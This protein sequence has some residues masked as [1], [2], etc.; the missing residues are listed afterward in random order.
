MIYL[1]IEVYYDELRILCASMGIIDNAKLLFFIYLMRKKYNL[2][3]FLVCF[4]IFLNG[5]ESKESKG[6]LSFPKKG[7]YMGI[8]TISMCSHFCTFCQEIGVKVGKKNTP[9]TLFAHDIMCILL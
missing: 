2:L 1:W 5:I 3:L 4:I 9:K 8:F 6:C 7:G